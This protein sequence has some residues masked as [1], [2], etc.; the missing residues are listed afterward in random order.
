VVEHSTESSQRIK[1]HETEVPTKTSGYMDTLVTEAIKT[2]LHP[3]NINTQEGF[4]P[5]KAWNP[6]T[7]LKRHSKTYTPHENPNKTQKRES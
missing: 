3:D 4:K 5:R 7:S 1:F 6:S 2:K